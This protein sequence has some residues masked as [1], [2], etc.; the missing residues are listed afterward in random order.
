MAA[1]DDSGSGLPHRWISRL[2][3]ARLV[4][5]AAAAVFAALWAF[6]ALALLPA[7]ASLAA[8]AAVVLIATGAGI[9]SPTAVSQSDRPTARPG[10]PLIEAVLEGIP[11]PVVALDPRGDV[12]ALNARARAIAPAL[13]RG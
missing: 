11:D 8:I 5:A 1:I 10:D 13:R 2:R 9:A 4:L 3:R 12:I 6:G 7:L